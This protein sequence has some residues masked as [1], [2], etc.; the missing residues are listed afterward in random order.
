MK[1][2]TTTA[3][4]SPERIERRL[5]LELSWGAV[6]VT[7]QVVAYQVKSVSTQATLDLLA[8]RPAGDDLRDRGDLVLP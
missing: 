3:I 5:G 6:S 4:E 7:E 2:D 1:K 8:P